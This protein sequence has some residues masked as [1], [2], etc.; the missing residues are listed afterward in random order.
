[1]RLGKMLIRTGALSNK[2]C[3]TK[4]AIKVTK[5]IIIRTS[6]LLNKH[7]STKQPIK[8]PETCKTKYI[9]HKLAL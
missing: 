5:K 4:L 7:C 1:M 8:L 3:S 2:N 6:A 9:D